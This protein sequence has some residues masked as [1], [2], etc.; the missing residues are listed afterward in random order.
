M[1]VVPVWVIWIWLDPCNFTRSLSECLSRKKRNVCGVAY[2]DP[3][4]SA[5]L[6]EKLFASGPRFYQLGSGSYLA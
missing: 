4:G 2:P 3:V 1:L 6:N 5:D